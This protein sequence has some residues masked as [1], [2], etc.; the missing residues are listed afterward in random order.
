MEI[1][2]FLLDRVNLEEK[3]KNG[4]IAIHYACE[5]GYVEIVKLLLDKTDLEAKDNNGRRPIH[6]AC[7][8]GHVEIVKLL[9]DKVNLEAEHNNGWRP[10][11]LACIEG[12]VEI[13]KLLVDGFI[14]DKI[15]A[16][17]PKVKIDCHNKQ[18]KTPLELAVNSCTHEF[19]QMK[20]EAVN[21]TL[22]AKINQNY[23]DIF[24]K[25]V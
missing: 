12:H 23:P 7:Y 2:K 11:H 24:I 9:L 13:V 6:H 17:V 21:R 22:F 20:L 25:L 10:I 5:K 18:N 1:V 16:T 15:Y 3:D 8:G 14:T 4:S 19:L